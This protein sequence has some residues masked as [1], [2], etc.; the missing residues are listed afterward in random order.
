MKSI[1]R[2]IALAGEQIGTVENADGTVKYSDEYG[3]PKQPWCMMF[4]WWLYKHTGLSDI[5]YGGKKVA[6]CRYF[7]EWALN[8][9]YV[10]KTPERGDIVILSFRR[11]P[12]GSK[13][14]SH[15][16]LITNVNTLSVDTIEGNTCAVGSQDNGGHV[17]SQRR[18]KTLVYAYIRLPYPAD[19]TE[20]ETLYIVQKNDTLW[21]IAKKYYGKGMMYTKIMK[22]NNLTSTTIKPGQMLIIKEV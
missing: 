11:L 2:V 20:P 3:L 21:G 4:L 19:E 14:T 15:C 1:E 18:K 6:S 22:D 13:E 8:K 9:G 10:V 7:Y 17:M 16:G 5:F 12:D